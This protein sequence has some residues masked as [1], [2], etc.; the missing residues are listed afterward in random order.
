MSNTT[1]VRNKSLHWTLW[2]AWTMEGKTLRYDFRYT[3]SYEFAVQACKESVIGARYEDFRIY[4]G[5]F[6]YN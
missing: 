6:E 5:D 1:Y 4:A 3:G 2:C